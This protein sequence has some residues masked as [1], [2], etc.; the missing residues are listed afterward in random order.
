MPTPSPEIIQLPAP[1]AAAMTA[2]TFQNALVL[3]WGVIL[4]PGR[5]TVAA[6]LR[7]VGLG[8]TPHFSNY[9][10]VLNRAHWSPLL[11]SR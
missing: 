2:P 6:A 3:L 10:R 9:H 4:S 8:E 5:R 7:V 1:F 11:L